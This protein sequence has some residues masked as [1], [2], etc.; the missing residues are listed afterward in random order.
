MAPPM[1]GGREAARRRRD[2]LERLQAAVAHREADLDGAVARAARLVAGREALVGE[3][4]LAAALA[5]DPEPEAGLG[6]VR[7]DVLLAEEEER[8]PAAHAG[9]RLGPPDHHPQRPP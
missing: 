2:R 6:G 8:P 9:G 4:D 1:L 5:R 7:P 3:R